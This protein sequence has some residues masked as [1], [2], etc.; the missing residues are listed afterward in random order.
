MEINCFHE[1]KVLAETKNF[2]EAADRLA[3]SE[4]T[5]SRHIKSLEDELGVSLFDRTSRSIR[6]NANGLLFLPYAEQFTSLYKRCTSA[7]NEAKAQKESTL[8]IASGYFVSDLLAKFHCENENISVTMLECRGEPGE[9]KDMLRREECELAFVMDFVDISNEFSSV[10]FDTD[11]YIAVMPL[12]H[13][14]AK[15]KFIALHDLINEPF[16]SFKANSYSD[17]KIKALCQEAG[18]EPKII[19]SADVGSSIAAF[20]KQGLGVSILQKKTLSKMD[21]TGI[22][23]VE[24]D[25]EIPISVFI[26]YLRHTKLSTAAKRFIEYSTEI[27]PK[28]SL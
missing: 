28:T 26:C 23:V 24:I 9:I 5:L 19:L 8:K 13:P 10:L 21:P 25:P 18:F 4:S 15:R 3:V 16:I 2:S 11:R 17:N 6:L 7:L 20:I 14:L 22:S 1:F 12:S 27:W